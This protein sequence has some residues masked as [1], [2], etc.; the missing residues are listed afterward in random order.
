MSLSSVYLTAHVKFIGANNLSS[1]YRQNKEF[2]LRILEG[3][4]LYF[5]IMLRR[6]TTQMLE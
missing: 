5:V 4:F 1:Y 3:I 6:S 2:S